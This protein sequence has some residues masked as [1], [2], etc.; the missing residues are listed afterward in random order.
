MQPREIV[1]VD[2]GDGESATV[3]QALGVTVIRNPAN[4][5]YGAGQNLG[6]RLTE[7]DYVILVNPDAVVVSAA[8]AAGLE[9][10]DAEADVAAVQG[11]IWNR[12]TARPERSQGVSLGPMHLIG[13]SVG[14]RRLLQFPLAQR[15]ARR[16]PRFADHVDRIPERPVD[17]ESLAAAAPLVRR[18]AFN[19]VGGF[20][21]GY[22]LYGEDLD[23]SR[24]L[25][26]AG[27]RLVSLPDRWAVHASGASSAGW[28]ER[29]LVWW[30]G[31][32]RYAALWWSAAEWGV[33][34]TATL[35]RMVPLAL[36]RP[37]RFPELVHRLLLR[38]IRTRRKGRLA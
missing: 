29:E 24:R 30:E 21:E 28:W 27:W 33:A 38:P 10:L 14:A 1:V 6:V 36:A 22:F 31:T 35:V 37:R 8:V 7:S 2:H 12:S 19:A 18:S 23:L 9:V 17:V 13:R 25:R 5:G 20:D 11:V 3:A 26:E 32:L 34:L 15:V 16:L 4:P